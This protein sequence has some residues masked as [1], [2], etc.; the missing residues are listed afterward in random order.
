MASF[1]RILAPNLVFAQTTNA[2][3]ISAR[4]FAT[5]PLSIPDADS[6]NP[7]YISSPEGGEYLFWHPTFTNPQGERV[8]GL[9]MRPKGEGRR[10]KG[11]HQEAQV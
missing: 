10:A 6:G 7:W 1:E 9:F 11:T 4:G 5:I 2:L 3:P 8:P